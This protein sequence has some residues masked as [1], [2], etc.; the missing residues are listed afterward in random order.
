MN[1][2][3]MYFIVTLDAIKFGTATLAGISFILACSATE[4]WL[5]M[6]NHF[7]IDWRFYWMVITWCI[8]LMFFLGAML[9]PT[10]QQMAAILVIP[11]VINN[12]RV[13]ALPEKVLGLAE[14]WIDKLK[15]SVLEKRGG[16]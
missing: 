5:P 13:Q 6:G 9:V 3:K 1:T 14:A 16:K 10:T 11:K 2:L 4:N 12:V 7:V 15:P 8:S